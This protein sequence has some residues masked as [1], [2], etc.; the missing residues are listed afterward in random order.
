VRRKQHAAF[1]WELASDNEASLPDKKMVDKLHKK[2]SKSKDAASLISNYGY[3][4][5]IKINNNSQIELDE[6]KLTNEAKWDGI[7]GLITNT[8]NLS[9]SEIISHYKGLCPN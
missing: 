7:Q 5:Y 3:K 2:L 4:K 6:T 9:A 1:L 8:K